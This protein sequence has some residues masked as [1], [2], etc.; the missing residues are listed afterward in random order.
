MP[1]TPS[2]PTLNRPPGQPRPDPFDFVIDQKVGAF[3]GG[4]PGTG[5]TPAVFHH[6]TKL[7]VWQGAHLLGDR[8][9]GRNTS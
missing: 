8:A 4:P 1:S 5:S 6:L 2:A 7:K 3:T 9:A